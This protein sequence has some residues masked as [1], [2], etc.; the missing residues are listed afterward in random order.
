VSDLLRDLGADVSTLGGNW[1]KY[2]VVGSF[3]LYV[4]GYLA[5]R[6]HLTAIGIG[7]DLAVLD[8]RY[9]F[10][11]ARFLVYLVS[12]V[13]SLLLLLLPVFVLLWG[14]AKLGPSLAVA[15]RSLPGRRPDAIAW[16]GV[17]VAVI[18]IQ[19]VMR[20][21]FLLNNLLLAPK[22]PADPAWLVDL[23]FSEQWTPIYFAGLVLMCGVSASIWIAVRNAEPL[24]LLGVSRGLLAFLVVVQVLL[25]PVNYGIIVMDRVLPRVAGVANEPIGNGDAAWLV[26]EGK[27]GVTFLIRRKNQQRVLL[28]LTHADVKRIEIVGF[29]PMVPTLFGGG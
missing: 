25:L 12:S 23:L 13:P 7:T 1:T 29:D 17:A 2:S 4:F 27:D 11:G 19:F 18:M 10:T 6:F 14:L 24:G 28:T 22:L 26:W 21:C 3:V 15:V 5:V 20:Q 16:C 9:L 8:E